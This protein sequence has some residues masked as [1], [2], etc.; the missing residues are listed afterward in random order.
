M[1]EFTS[2]SDKVVPI[3]T[4]QR[5]LDSISL[6]RL[7]AEMHQ[8]REKA[9]HHL[10]AMLRGLIDKTDDALFEL[11]DQATNNHDQNLYFD[12]MR[13]VRLRRR[14]TEEGFFRQLD[15]AF[16]R[17][18]HTSEVQPEAADEPELDNLSLVGN[19]E[20][21]EMVASDTMINRANEQFA[22]R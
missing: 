5:R 4:E 6:A 2:H 11:A 21:E 13:Q 7:P 10:H 1:S 14:E 3:G 9:R 20:L 19:D 8:V 12:S 16:A 15:K 22:E 17:L 18:L